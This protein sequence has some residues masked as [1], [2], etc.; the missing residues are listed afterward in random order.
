[1]AHGHILAGTS[2][3]S[4][5]HWLGTFYPEGIPHK[6]WLAYYAGHFRSVE[7]NNTFYHLPDKKVL[8]QWYDI[9]PDDF[10]FTAKA[11]RYITHMKK[12]KDPQTSVA[13]FF[14]RVSVLED[15][16]GPIIF[17]LPPHWRFNP[18]RL[19]EF[20]RVLSADYQYAFEF[21]DHSWHT[22]QT[23]DLLKKWLFGK[24]SG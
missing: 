8:Q 10:V 22:S 9:V 11:S 3:W 19:E 12:L 21:R 14:E 16:L 20:L 5:D 1:M 24:I 6:Q 2:G 18:Q 7:I 15:K 4:Y 23:L 13:A 17:Q